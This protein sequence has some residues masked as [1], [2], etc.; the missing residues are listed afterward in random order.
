[1]GISWEKLWQTLCWMD[2]NH[3]PSQR[4]NSTVYRQELMSEPCHVWLSFRSL[5]AGKLTSKE[6]VMKIVSVLAKKCL[7]LYCFVVGKIQ[8][9]SNQN[10]ARETRTST[11]I[12]LLQPQFFWFYFTYFTSLAFGKITYF[13]E[14]I[15]CLSRTLKI[16]NYPLVRLLM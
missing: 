5:S 10:G 4:I 14:M 16:N 9:G 2:G 7:T 13:W 12:S 1:M 15:H 8:N 11:W 6:E 3:M